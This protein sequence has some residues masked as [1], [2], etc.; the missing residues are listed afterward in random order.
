MRLSTSALLTA[1]L[2]PLFLHAQIT[3][4]R[5]YGGVSGDYG[6]SVQQ[7]S[8]CGYVIAGFTS[9]FGGDDDVYLVR[10]NA[11]GDTLWTRTFGGPLPDEGLSVQQTSDSGYIVTG[12][13]KSFGAGNADVY[14]IKTN[15]SGDTLWTRTYGGTDYD[16]GWS[17]QQTSD[18]GYIITG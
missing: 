15:A 14:L 10:T 6:Y 4:Q 2:L 18:R 1:L 12:W 3:F 8:D 17:V 11:S 13:T 5:T 9:S 16:D 7:T